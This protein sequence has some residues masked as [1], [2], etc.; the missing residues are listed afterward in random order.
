M[1]PFGLVVGFVAGAATAAL[2][3][4]QLAQQARPAAKAVLKAA[5]AAMHEVQVRGAE[6]VEAAEDLYAEATAEVDEEIAEAAAASESGEEQG[7]PQDG[8]KAPSQGQPAKL[9]PHTPTKVWDADV[10][11][12]VP[13]P[14]LNA[15]AGIVR[16]CG[17]A[18]RRRDSSLVA[19]S[20][21][22]ELDRVRDKFLRK[23]L[24]L[25]HTDEELDR[26]IRA[27]G[28]KMKRTTAK[29]RVTV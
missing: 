15:I 24:G 12:Y 1:F 2:F 11:R 25:T 22:A 16:H 3:T 8:A 18:L 6:A 21:K 13:N 9:R 26:A 14:D 23:K 29:N 17:I 28:D 27:V 10:K 4:P 19:F 20:D 7:E 5:L